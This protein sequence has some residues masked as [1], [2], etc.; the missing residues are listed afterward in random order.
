VVYQSLYYH[1]HLM[2]AYKIS[3]IY[4]IR[5]HQMDMVIKRL[6]NHFSTS[7]RVVKEMKT[8]QPKFTKM[9]IPIKIIKCIKTKNT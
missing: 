1:I 8:S 2:M 6:I 7:S 4:S 5:H 9:K 3:L